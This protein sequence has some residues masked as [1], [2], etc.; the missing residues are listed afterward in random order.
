MKFISQLLR[1]DSEYRSVLQNYSYPRAPVILSGLCEGMTAALL[2]TLVEDTNRKLLLIVPDEEEARAFREELSGFKFNTDL[3]PARDFIFGDTEAASRDFEHERL[4]VLQK[5]LTECEII[6]T[7]AEAACQTT[8][9][10]ELLAGAVLTLERGKEYD[11][12]RLSAQI[13]ELGYERAE[14]V[15]GRG[16]FSV[17]G[18][19]I[20]IF[21]STSDTPYRIE[22]FG[23]EVDSINFLDIMTQRRYGLENRVVI[24]PATELYLSADT[25]AALIKKL[26]AL[27]N[28]AAAVEAIENRGVSAPDLYLDLIYQ[29]P[30]TLFD[31]TDGFIIAAV[32][33][34]RLKDRLDSAAWRLDENIKSICEKSEIGVRG[35]PLLRWNEFAEKIKQ[36][37]GSIIIDSFARG[38]GDFGAS[39]IYSFI[40]KKTLGF[41]DSFEMLYDD[42][43]QY[44]DTGYTT[45]LLCGSSLSAATLH[46]RL[47][48]EGIECLS[49][50]PADELETGKIYVMPSSSG[51]E[52]VT[53]KSGFE[54]PRSKFVLLTD[55][56]VVSAKTSRRRYGKKT[57]NKEKILSY[58]DLKTGDYIVHI[59]HGI[60]IYGGIKSISSDGVQ[61]DYMVINYAEGD[62]LY[63]PCSNLDSVSKYIGKDS[64][65][66]IKIHRMDS[67]DWKKAKVRAK[68]AASDIARELMEL[69]A[70]RRA[71]KGYA[72]SPDT[73]WQREFEDAF[74]YA[75]TDGQ[76]TAAED[77]KR[78]MES[79][80]PMDRLLCGDVG[81]GKTEV[82]MRGIFKCVMD[83]KQAAILVPTTILAWQHYQTMLSRF[84]GFPIRIAMLSRFTSPKE[85]KRVIQ[86]LKDGTVDIVVGTHKLLNKNIVFRDLGFIVIDEE[87]RFGVSHKE[88]LKEM[89]VGV[90]V[91]TLTATPI[92]RTLNMALS[93]IRDMSILEEAPGDRFPVQT[94]VLEHDENVV[95][96][97]VRRELKRGGQC[98]YLLNNIELLESRAAAVLKACP[99]ASVAT[100]HGRLG[101]D[102]LA[103][104][105]RDMAEGNIDVLVCTTI[106]E[107]GIDVPNANTIIIEN[108]DRY[109][110]SQLHQIRG[111]VGRSSRK[112]YA[113]LTFRKNLMLSEIAEKRLSAI[114]EY[115]EFGSGFKIAMRDLELRGAGDLLGASQ[116]GHMDVVGYDLYIK[117]LDEAIREAKGETVEELP[118]TSVDITADAY[119]PQKYIATE[120]SRINIYRKIAAVENSDDMMELT[121][122]LIDRYGD[123][124]KPVMNLMKISILRRMAADCGIKKAVQRE[125][126]IY[127][128]TD[129]AKK[130]F[131]DAL[132]LFHRDISF[133]S[134]SSPY[135]R[136]KVG[137]G[138]SLEVL[139]QLLKDY[140]QIIN[141]KV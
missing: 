141:S 36:S 63:V 42:L 19:I 16:Q 37:R 77:I 59:N 124:P 6:V 15:E 122:E 79:D 102:E 5:A 71:A 46:D 14:L 110:L 87:Q 23:D 106:I 123:V 135:I 56:S 11:L 136:I 134:G 76:L 72:F 44:R 140:K 119:I 4:S 107:T 113:Y 126:T 32:D 86:G 13:S 131:A 65:K 137:C 69:Y 22:F 58:T 84:R 80:V 109:G 39:H 18:D 132:C 50:T 52:S 94:Y 8:I 138:K 3:F 40:S 57:S 104:I 60:G 24:P 75:E 111:R 118:E 51:G 2:G 31:Y 114:K 68:A 47:R 89:S 129:L 88:K 98:F 125:D 30:A 70:K 12:H 9:P 81:F 97:A 7:T 49:A 27:K 95:F 66:Q 61:K 1:A 105:W 21:P 133:V 26:S 91:L 54:L 20:D 101:R 82:A 55:A 100:A 33:T 139:E 116:H 38:E 130:Q 28:S 99:T 128:Y 127:L 43:I 115:T 53:L 64:D 112:A 25:K 121:D 62:V 83:N 103:D 34:A 85:A 10:R 96:D 17:R 108:A 92:P 48:G 93:G 90:D 120:E 74:E 41:A 35:Y 45:V 67:S 73:E 117:L 29:K 78:D